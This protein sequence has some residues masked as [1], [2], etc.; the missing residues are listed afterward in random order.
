MKTK[1][2]EEELLQLSP[3]ELYAEMEYLAE[4]TVHKLFPQPIRR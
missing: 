4:V 3:E 2:S 1:L